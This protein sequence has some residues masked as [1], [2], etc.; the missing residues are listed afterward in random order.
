MKLSRPKAASA[1]SGGILLNH[2]SC[3][4]LAWASRASRLRLSTGRMSTV[5][6]M[7]C[8]VSAI[9]RITSGL[10][11][12]G[13][14]HAGFAQ[15]LPYLLPVAAAHRGEVELGRDAGARGGGDGCFGRVHV[16]RVLVGARGVIGDHDLRLVPL[17]QGADPPGHLG[18]GDVA[19]GAGPVLV[20]PVRHAGVV[21]AERLKVGDAQDLAGLA[22]LRQ[23]QLRH[24]LLVVT[25]LAGLDSTGRI[26][27]LTVRAGHDHGTDSLVTVGGQHAAGARCLVVGVC[28]YRHQGEI[29]CHSPKFAARMDGTGPQHGPQ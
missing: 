23:P 17:D 1:M 29:F 6:V 12:V 26:P 15:R 11:A 16:V 5:V 18:S 19:E 24:H 4:W 21:I 7:R 10:G 20:V 3:I 8:S 13:Y 2:E 28:V 9:C 22:Q 27:E 25:V 14:I